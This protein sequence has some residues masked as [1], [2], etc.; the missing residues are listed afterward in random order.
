M[1]A[2]ELKL[3]HGSR[4]HPVFHVSLLKRS[5][6]PGVTVSAVLPLVDNDDQFT[7]TPTR[8]LGLKVVIRG[9]LLVT[10][11]LI[12]WSHSKPKD[13]TWEDL[14]FIQEQF[15]DFSTTLR[16]LTLSLWTRMFFR[17]GGVIDIREN[18]VYNTWISNMRI[19][20]PA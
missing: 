19:S 5:T 9:L 20:Y 4:I 11:V 3:P 10:Q 18:I 6:Y 2:Y 15:P 17:S 7:L 1:V 12:Q 14:S 16:L 8:I 13:A